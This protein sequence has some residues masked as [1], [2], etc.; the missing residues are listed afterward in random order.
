M[1]SYLHIGTSPVAMRQDTGGGDVIIDKFEAFEHDHPSLSSQY[2]TTMEVGGAYAHLFFD[3]LAFLEL[4]TLIITDID[5]VEKP[6]G[7]ACLVHEGTVTSN[8]CIKEWFGEENALAVLL[9]KS[10]EERVRGYQRIAYQCPEEEGGPCGRSFEDAFILANPARFGIEDG[11][12]EDR[13]T[14]ARDAAIPLKKSKFALQYAIEETDWTTPRYILDG[15]RWLARTP[16]DAPVG[17]EAVPVPADP[18]GATD[19]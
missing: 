7:K 1:R 19:A 10:D 2:V 15:I 9:A 17:V 12:P 5:A 4:P 18:E 6:G 8:A 14:A 11:A 3:L 13:A 16:V